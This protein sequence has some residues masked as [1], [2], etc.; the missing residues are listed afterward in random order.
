M[1]CASC[2]AFSLEILRLRI[3]QEASINHSFSFADPL[4][5][6]P[7]GPAKDEPFASGKHKQLGKWELYVRS[8]L[9]GRAHFHGARVLH[10]HDLTG[11]VRENVGRQ[12]HARTSFERCHCVQCL[13]SA[14]TQL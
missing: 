1:V 7:L 2:L 10:E 9:N 6:S 11:V 12:V 8:N 14:L 4:H 13:L 3:T 5:I